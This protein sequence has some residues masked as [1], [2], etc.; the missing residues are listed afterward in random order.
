MI[1]RM[2]RYT[3]LDRMTANEQRIHLKGGSLRE[4]RKCTSITL[5]PFIT[6][7]VHLLIACSAGL[8]I[9]E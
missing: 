9:P 7:R 3:I 2:D 4:K 6:H 5:Y 1:H 8:I